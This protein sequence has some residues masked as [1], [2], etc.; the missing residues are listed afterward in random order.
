MRRST[1]VW[2]ALILTI[3]LNIRTQANGQAVGFAPRIGVVPDGVALNVAPVA[4][5]DRRYVRMG[6]YPTI[7]NFGG[8]EVVTV[9]AAVGGGGFGGG[10]GGVPLPAN[11]A[12]TQGS[13]FSVR[14][15]PVPQRSVSGLSEGAA[16]N[17][18]AMR[19][20]RATKHGAR[21]R[22]VRRRR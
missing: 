17:S 14:D 18:G 2:L 19:S 7:V 8:F 15:R 10:L 13:P 4:S 3:E 22:T 21:G 5:A 9:P 1:L 6:A 16:W 20:D 11:F 12:M